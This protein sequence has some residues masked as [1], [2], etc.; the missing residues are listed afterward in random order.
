V[1]KKIN[2]HRLHKWIGLIAAI[3]LLVLGA[4]GFVLDHREWRWQWQSGVSSHW[5]PES[6]TETKEIDQ[7]KLY[8]LHLHNNLQQVA[9]GP[10]GLWWTEDAGDH[11]QATMFKGETPFVYKLLRSNVADKLWIASGNGLWLS[12]DFGVTAI[13]VALPSEPVTA[14]APGF[15]KGT[16]FGVVDRSRVFK[17]NVKDNSVNWLALAPLPVGQPLKEIELSRLVRDLHFGR[18]VVAPNIDLFLNDVTGIGLVVLAISGFL[19][20]WLPKRWK[21]H[22]Q[23]AHVKKRTIQQLYRVHSA[24]CGVLIAIPIIYLGIT[25]IILDHADDLRGWLKA[26]KVPALLHAPTYSRTDW[27]Q[28]IYGIATL[29]NPE[30]LL[31]GGRYG[32]MVSEEPGHQWRQDQRVTGF[33]WTLTQQGEHLFIGGMGAPNR[34][35]V[36]ETWHMAPKTG[37][38]PSSVTTDKRGW[39][40]WKNKEGVKAGPLG[41]LAHKETITLPASTQTPWY[42]VFDGLHTG[43]LIHP[44]WP[45]INDFFAVC[46]ILL[47][48]TGLKRWWRRKWL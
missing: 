45:W 14:L 40:Y 32:L 3:W 24:T 19:F 11:W 17:F 34:F 10:T 23:A 12:S 15:E 39:V 36:D 48:I 1:A 38:M 42:Y 37:H 6:F 22:K 20:F 8:Q 29:K 44:Y 30:R 9:G 43:L 16:L 31:L 46:S 21:T 41:K 7:F 5:L 28:Q 35:W 13:Q 2:S 18:G 25:G 47:V 26:T 27:N 4:T 33:V